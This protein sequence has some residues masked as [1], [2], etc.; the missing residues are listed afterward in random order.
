MPSVPPNSAPVS[1]IA[2]AGPAGSAEA[3]PTVRSAARVSTGASPS[4]NTTDPVTS[5][6]RPVALSSWVSSRKP[7]ATSSSP[8]AIATTGR[9]RRASTG[10]SMEPRMNPAADGSIHKT[11]L[12]WRQAQH[13]LQ[14]LGNEQQGAEPDDEAEYVGGQG[15]V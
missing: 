2:D 1:E 15:C 8:P 10:V 9:A 11:S 6:G 5:T 14:V 13:Q 3:A 7:T 4:E 12:Q